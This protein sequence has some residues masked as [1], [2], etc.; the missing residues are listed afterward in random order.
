MIVPFLSSN[1]IT[2][3][4]GKLTDEF[5]STLIQL[6]TNLRQSI[7]DEGFLIPSV[8]NSDMAIIESGALIGTVVFNT[9]AVNGSTSMTPN[10]QLYIK[11]A[12]GVFHAI[13]NL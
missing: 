1:N 7:G 3:E 10:G 5:F 8:T 12:D 6:L 13:Q 9:D 2:D 4:N 11:L